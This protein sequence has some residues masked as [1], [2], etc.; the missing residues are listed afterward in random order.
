MNEKLT[1]RESKIL[2][3]EGI[4]DVKFFKAILKFLGIQNI[5]IIGVEGKNNFKN[6][7]KLISQEIYNKEFTVIVCIRDAD[8]NFNGAFRSLKDALMAAG[9]PAPEKVNSFKNT[10][11]L[12]TG[13][14]IL[15]ENNENGMIEDLCIQTIDKELLQCINNYYRC[16][17]INP[18]NKS[19]STV[20][21]FLATQTPLVNSLGNASEHDIWDF[22]HESFSKIKGFLEN[23]R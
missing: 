15:P 12:K 5:Q 22:N 7:L 11:K 18:K 19:K 3:V 8:S 1:I 17:N 21:I 20:Q 23:L 10:D 6:I 4:D 14:Y 2:L 9:F 16:T 13:I